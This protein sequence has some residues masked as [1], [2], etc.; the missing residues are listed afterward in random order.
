MPFPPINLSPSLASS[1][2]SFSKLWDFAELYKGYHWG[3]DPWENGFPNILRLEADITEAAKNDLIGKEQ[4][5]SVV[6][7]GNLRN[8]A[9]V[10]CPETLVVY[11]FDVDRS[12]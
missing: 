4:V 8:P 3:I 2:T 7:W 12:R 9:R 11:Q 6:S 1:L 10:K 5:L